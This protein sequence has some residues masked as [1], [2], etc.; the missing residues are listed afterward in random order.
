MVEGVGKLLTKQRMF[1]YAQ[2]K[3]FEGTLIFGGTGVKELW[4]DQGIWT[5]DRWI[6]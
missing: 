4:N 2:W 6:V 3:G 1:L 5:S